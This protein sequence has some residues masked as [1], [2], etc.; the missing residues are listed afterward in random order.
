MQ[1]GLIN[2][3]IETLRWWCGNNNAFPPLRVYNFMLRGASLTKFIKGSILILNSRWN[4]SSEN[5][6]MR[7]MG[8]AVSCCM[9]IIFSIKFT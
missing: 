9:G 6:E 2:N 1:G 5:L 4:N 8:K 3:V 7:E